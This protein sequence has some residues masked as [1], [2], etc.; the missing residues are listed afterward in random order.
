MDANL[1]Q[2][3]SRKTMN[4]YNKNDEE[5]L[6]LLL[7]LQEKTSPIRMSIGYTVDGTVCQGI[8]LH[9]AP[10]MVIETL[11]EHGYICTLRDYGMCV[12]KL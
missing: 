9:E 12:E 3:G 5:L 10:P 4:K 6:T 1:G 2:E 8:I 7:K 11:I